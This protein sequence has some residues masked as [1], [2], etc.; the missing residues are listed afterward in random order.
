MKRP[1][2][3]ALGVDAIRH[4][5]FQCKVAGKGTRPVVDWRDAELLLGLLDKATADAEFLRFDR[6]YWRKRAEEL[7]YKTALAGEGKE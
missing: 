3:K 6:D 5:V 2:P 1:K 4:K 7:R